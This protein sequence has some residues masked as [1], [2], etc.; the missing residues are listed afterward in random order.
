MKK[1]VA[2]LLAVFLLVPGIAAAKTQV[3]HTT[4][5]RVIYDKQEKGYF[6]E[7]EADKNGVWYLNILYVNK[8]NKILLKSLQQHLL[9]KKID[10][11]YEDYDSDD[12]DDWEMIEYT[13]LN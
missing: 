5:K 6:F 4:I 8:E 11:T 10:I 1:V 9:N 12:T 13:I 2:I 3:E 7:T